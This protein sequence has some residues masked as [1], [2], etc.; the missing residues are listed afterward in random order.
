MA[1]TTITEMLLVDSLLKIACFYKKHLPGLAISKIIILLRKRLRMSQVTLAKR[2]KI[3]QATLSRIESG[4]VEP[5]FKILEKIFGA[6]FCDIVMIP[7]PQ[8]DLDEIVQK[9]IRHLAEKRIKYL[10]GT[11]ALELQQP[12]DDVIDALI[13]REEKEILSKNSDIWEEGG[14]I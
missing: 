6:L 2:A 11:M 1:R 14:N 3:H 13:A 10:K 5:T 9:R 12:K 8:R 4:K 7:L